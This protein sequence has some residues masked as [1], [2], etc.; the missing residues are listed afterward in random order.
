MTNGGECLDGWMERVKLRKNRIGFMCVMLRQM[1]PGL[2]S[3]HNIGYSHGDLKLE[4]ICARTS[5]NENFKFTLIDFGM[6]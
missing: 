3:L 6:S 5:T 1:I 2:A 4:N